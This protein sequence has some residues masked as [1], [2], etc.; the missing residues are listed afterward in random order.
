[1]RDQE[2]RHT[3]LDARLERVLR[4]PRLNSGF[5]GRLRARIKRE[6]WSPLWEGMPDVLHLSGCIVAT[7]VCASVLALDASVTL[8]AGMAATLAS[9]VLMTAVRSALEDA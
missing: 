2:D 3:R 5:R 6:S 7:L 1:M 4:A 9:Y 8:A